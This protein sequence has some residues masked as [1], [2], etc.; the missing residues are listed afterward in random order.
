MS[1]SC[2][3]DSCS[4]SAP[5]YIYLKDEAGLPHEFYIA[6]NL[7]VAHQ[8]YVFLAGTEAE[9][10]YALLKVVESDDGQQRYENIVAESEWDRLKELLFS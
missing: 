6:D 10:Q 7:T 1:C 4:C 9:N 2:G 5:Q 3:Q 8:K